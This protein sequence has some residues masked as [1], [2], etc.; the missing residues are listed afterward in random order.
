MQNFRPKHRRNKFL[1]FSHGWSSYLLQTSLTAIAKNPIK[2]KSRFEDKKS[3]Q[4]TIDHIIRKQKKSILTRNVSIKED[5]R[6]AK[7][8]KI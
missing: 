5:K 2:L 1:T 4:M 7:Q 3:C 8:G 6:D